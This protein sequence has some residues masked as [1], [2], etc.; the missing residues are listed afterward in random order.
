VH[1]RVRRRTPK[2]LHEHDE[3]LSVAAFVE[4]ID[5]YERL[6]PDLAEFRAAHARDEL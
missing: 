5:I 6:I 3:F 4:G 2:L 1:A